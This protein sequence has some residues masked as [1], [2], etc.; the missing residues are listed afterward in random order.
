MLRAVVLAG[1]LVAVAA[2]ATADELRRETADGHP[3]QYYLSLPR[4]FEAKRTWP[5]V[6]V[7]EAAEKRFEENARRFVAA[8]GDLPFIIVA[9]I[10]VTNGRSGQRDPAIYPYSTAVW[11]GIDKSGVCE[12]DLAGIDRVLDKVR[13]EHHGDGRVFLTGFEAG[14]HLVW[15]YALLHPERLRAVAPVA[16]NYIGRCVEEDKISTHPARRALPIRGFVGANDAQFG[17]SGAVHAQWEAARKLALAHGFAS[18]VETVV[19][20][21]EHV[22]LPADVLAWFAELAR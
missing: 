4:G 21:R 10:V 5:V 7:V 9:P 3:M 16:G 11:D 13:R 2:P 14:T 8:R 22:P 20:G 15:A 6:V 12:F 18:I 1:N 17:P 19:A